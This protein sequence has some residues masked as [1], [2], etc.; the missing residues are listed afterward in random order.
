MFEL[1]FMLSKSQRRDWGS[2]N[3]SNSANT[4]AARHFATSL[5]PVKSLSRSFFL[6]PSFLCAKTLPGFAG[7]F[8]LPADNG[9]VIGPARFDL[10]TAHAKHR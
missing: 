1:R 3:P 6:S 5:L 7:N 9:I 10:R 8:P 4:R 2:T